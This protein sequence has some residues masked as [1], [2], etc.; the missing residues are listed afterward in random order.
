MRRLRRWDI[1]GNLVHPAARLSDKRRGYRH[2]QWFF[3]DSRTIHC[4][5]AV[6][7]LG[8]CSI[9]RLFSWSKISSFGYLV[10]Q[11]TK[12]NQKA[13]HPYRLCQILDSILQYSLRWCNDTQNGHRA[14]WFLIRKQFFCLMLEVE[15]WVRLFYVA[16]MTLTLSFCQSSWIW[17]LSSDSIPA[18]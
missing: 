15:E 12:C 7:H 3:E 2:N 9:H 4:G 5:V 6:F 18:W 11:K 17:L 14:C 1:K 13:F 16:T 8:V 10:S